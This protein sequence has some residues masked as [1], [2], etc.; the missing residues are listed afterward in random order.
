MRLNKSR[1]GYISVIT[2]KFH[3]FRQFGAVHGG[4]V[5]VFDNQLK[6]RVYARYGT[7]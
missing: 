1:I 4:V 5:N 3:K 7:R 6:R 2:G